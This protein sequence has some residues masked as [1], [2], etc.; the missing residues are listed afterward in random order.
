MSFLI[1]KFMCVC[2]CVCVERSVFTTLQLV[3]GSKGAGAVGTL[4]T[5]SKAGWA[6]CIELSI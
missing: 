6:M 5:L 2:V 4:V 3:L 1:I